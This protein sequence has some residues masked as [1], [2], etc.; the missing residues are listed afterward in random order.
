[1]ESK[2]RRGVI[3]Q[4]VITSELKKVFSGSQQGAFKSVDS[5]M[6]FLT[7]NKFMKKATDF[8][9]GGDNVWKFYADEFLST[10]L[11]TSY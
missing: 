1:L 7:K 3:D 10:S 9:A 11:K 4:N 2:L 6:D 8:Y 5:L